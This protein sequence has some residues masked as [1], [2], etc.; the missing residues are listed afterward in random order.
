M[1]GEISEALE[2]DVGLDL[3]A[4][5]D[6]EVQHRSLQRMKNKLRIILNLSQII[7]GIPFNLSVK[8]PDLYSGLLSFLGFTALSFGW[9]PIECLYKVNHYEN[10]AFTTLG[11]ITASLCLLCCHFS[12]AKRESGQFYFFLL[13]NFLYLILPGTSS[14]VVATFKCDYFSD[15]D[16]SYT[17]IDYTLVCES[18]GSKSS[19]R[20][21][22]ETYAIVMIFLFPLGIPLMFACKKGELGCASCWAES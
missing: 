9:V 10:L 17:V 11:S 5:E 2:L 18:N 12:A 6:D 1:L 7:S 16:T 15:T 19:T 21:F 8:F 3:A 20:V 22:W 4:N 14:V 13:L